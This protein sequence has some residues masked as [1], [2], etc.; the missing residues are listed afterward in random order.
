VGLKKS[1]K[2]LSFSKGFK[3][4]G[5]E[6]LAFRRISELKAFNLS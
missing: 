2:L 3:L 6:E 1:S 4:M 5:L